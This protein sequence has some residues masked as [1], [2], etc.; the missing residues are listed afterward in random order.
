MTTLLLLLT[1]MAVLAGVLALR[2]AVRRDGLGTRR[3]P[4]SHREWWEGAGLS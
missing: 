2:R 3:P 1:A 4:R